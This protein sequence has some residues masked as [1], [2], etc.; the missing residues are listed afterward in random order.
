M[1]IE[2]DI[3]TVSYGKLRLK[4]LIWDSAGRELLLR[5]FH[6]VLMLYDTTNRQS[7]E[8]ISC[9]NHAV[10]NTSLLKIVVGTKTDLEDNR[11]V[12]HVEARELCDSLGIAH[13]IQVSSKTADNVEKTFNT[14]VESLVRHVKLFPFS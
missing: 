8:N 13:H 4:L 2:Y 10:G 1:G 9:W 12:S 3:R 11:Q 7:F 14:L 5:R 6:A